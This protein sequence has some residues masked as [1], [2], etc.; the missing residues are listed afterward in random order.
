MLC[1]ADMDLL[2][3]DNNAVEGIPDR[4]ISEL[5]LQL[6]EAKGG[7]STFILDCC[8]AAGINQ[9]MQRPGARLRSRRILHPPQISPN[10]DSTISSYAS[11]GLNVTSGFSGSSWDSHIVL[12]ACTIINLRGRKMGRVFLLAHC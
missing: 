10:Y 8:H 12:A 3:E 2:D 5:L 1:P 7:N 6:S 9:D 4:A 11:R